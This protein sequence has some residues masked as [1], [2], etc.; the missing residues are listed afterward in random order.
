MNKVVTS[1]SSFQTPSE[2]KPREPT[3]EAYEPHL[4]RADSVKLLPKSKDRRAAVDAAN[5]AS[6]KDQQ[7]NSGA[8]DD[9]DDEVG[10]LTSG[11]EN[12]HGAYVSTSNS[13]PGLLPDAQTAAHN[14][15]LNLGLPNQGRFTDAH[16]GQ[17][18]APEGDKKAPVSTQNDLPSADLLH[19]S[20][21]GV[22][23]SS[24]SPISTPGSQHT[25]A[26]VDHQATKSV[27][28]E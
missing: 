21:T 24:F 6:T 2:Q 27:T 16:D 4:E 17:Q 19:K 22:N 15:T 14:K 11:K 13:K 5:A 9:N 8:T 12:H 1:S 25:S 23:K 10:A 7:S 3:Y 28:K 20:L 18:Q 26:F